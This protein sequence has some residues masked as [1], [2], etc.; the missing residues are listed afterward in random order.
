MLTDLRFIDDQWTYL[1]NIKKISQID[2]E[3]LVAEA[4]TKGRVI[5]VRL[6]IVEEEN[7]TPWKTPT[8]LPIMDKLPQKLHL[9]M[10]NEIFIEKE[11]LPASLLNRLIRG[12]TRSHR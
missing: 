2:A 6:E 9:V 3:R 1:A 5:G 4:E 7:K 12:P 10:S 8:S 11:M